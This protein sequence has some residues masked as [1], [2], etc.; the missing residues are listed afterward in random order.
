MPR[1]SDEHLASARDEAMRRAYK[2]MMAGNEADANT[3]SLN[4][5]IK[6]DLYGMFILIYR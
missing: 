6:T 1:G 5:L 2:E 4:R 3:G